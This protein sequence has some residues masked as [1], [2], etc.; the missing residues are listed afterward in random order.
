M[1]SA[2]AVVAALLLPMLGSSQVGDP[3]GSTAVFL[4]DAAVSS[5][6][7]AYPA[8]LEQLKKV[9]ETEAGIKKFNV[10]V[11]DVTGRWV[12][13]KGF[14]K[15]DAETR[16][17][18]FEQL[19]Q[20]VPEGACDLSAALDRLTTPLFDLPKGAKLHVYLLSE[21]DFQF[22][23]QTS[24]NGWVTWNRLNY[25][26]VQGLIG[27]GQLGITRG[28]TLDPLGDSTQYGPGIQIFPRPHF[29]FLLQWLFQRFPGF[30][31]DTLNY[32]ELLLHYYF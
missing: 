1:R 4:L 11:F 28:A 9:L 5:E 18:I 6:V 15:N 10:L 20:V 26:F 3:P 32:G 22:F 23:H 12:E 29:E 21:L 2:I 8:R 24:N 19:R 25:E 17:L 27:Y 13:P 30:P 7:D 31:N 16:Q 14:L